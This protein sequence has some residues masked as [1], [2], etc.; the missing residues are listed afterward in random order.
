MPDILT[1]R[2]IPRRSRLPRLALIVVA[3]AAVVFVGMSLRVGVL[4]LIKDRFAGYRLAK[5]CLDFKRPQ[6]FVAY[7]EDIEI[8]DQVDG[9]PEYLLLGR[10]DSDSKPFID[11]GADHSGIYLTYFQAAELATLEKY[12]PSSLSLGPIKPWRGDGLGSL[13]Y[14]G[15]RTTKRGKERLVVIECAWVDVWIPEPVNMGITGKPPRKLCAATYSPPGFDGPGKWGRR[16]VWDK[17]V[18]GRGLGPSQTLYFGQPD[19]HEKS[20]FTIKCSTRGNYE[21]PTPVVSFI[22]GELDDDGDDVVVRLSE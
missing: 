12:A 1:Y 5:A 3:S 21:N 16:T 9:K 13:V 17:H 10:R 11:V 22:H 19:P 6:D 18:F 15:R 4:V 2:P 7:G 14:M 8:A 20:S